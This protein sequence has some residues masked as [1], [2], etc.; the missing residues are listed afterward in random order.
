M[1]SC[2]L[3]ALIAIRRFGHSNSTGL[4]WLVL[5]GPDETAFRGASKFLEVPLFDEFIAGVWCM[6]QT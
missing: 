6:K 3:K 2:A 1:L 4:A 5:M